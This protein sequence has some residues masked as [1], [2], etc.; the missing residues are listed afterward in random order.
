M[1]DC[2]IQDPL[3]ENCHSL[4]VGPLALKCP[5]CLPKVRSSLY[6]SEGVKY[7]WNV[8]LGEISLQRIKLAQNF[9]LME[10]FL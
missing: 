7:V 2:K 6:L 4:A 9:W 8:A 1:V 5:F 10:D 3:V